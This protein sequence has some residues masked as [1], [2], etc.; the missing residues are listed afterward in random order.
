M[1]VP[2]MQIRAEG[3]AALAF[4]LSGLNRIECSTDNGVARVGRENG[5]LPLALR[6]LVG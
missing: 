4:I 6:D 3:R 1:T 5:K 2:R